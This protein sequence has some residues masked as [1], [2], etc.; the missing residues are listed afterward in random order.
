MTFTKKPGCVSCNLCFANDNPLNTR[1][2]D[3]NGQSVPVEKK[4]SKDIRT[5]SPVILITPGNIKVNKGCDSNVA[6]VTWPN[7]T[8]DF[9]CND[10]ELECEGIHLES[11]HVWDDAHVHKGGVFPGGNNNFCCSASNDCLNKVEKCWTVTVNDETSLEVEVQFSPTMKTKG[12]PD[13]NDALT[14]CIKFE[15]F[16][17]CV[18][19][20]ICFSANLDFGGLFNLVGHFNGPVK[21]PAAVQ[22]ACIT[23]RDQRH[24]LRSCYTFGE[25]DCDPDGILH[26]TFKQDPFFGGNWLIGGNLDGWK[27]SNP[28]ASHDVIDILDFGTL[29]SQWLFPLPPDT[30]C[31]GVAP[32]DCDEA[33]ASHADINGDGI[34]DT[35]DFSFVAMNFLDNSK[36]CCCPGSASLGNAVGRAEISVR[37]LREQG[38][39]DLAVADLNAD[40]KVDMAD[41]AALMQG[42]RPNL[43]ANDGGKN[44]S[45][46]NNRK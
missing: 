37:E 6:T 12:G 45:R 10:G 24:T 27:K 8:A 15:V 34:V 33:Q 23:A 42:V 41:M 36:D 46:S 13:G 38:M 21:I 5:K 26:A 32:Y 39:T 30:P 20:P 40:G 2:S 44:G 3:D 22:P 7:P 1:L 31:N 4:C 29:V 17:N 14:R 18:Q 35:L 28:N 11:G 43:K 9:G 16:N 19:A 25:G